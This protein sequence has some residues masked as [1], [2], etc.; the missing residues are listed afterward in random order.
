[1]KETKSHS[2]T[3]SIKVH[4]R[5]RLPYTIHQFPKSNALPKDAV[6]PSH[7]SLSR[8]LEEEPHNKYLQSCHTNHHQAFNYT[9]IKD[10]PLRTPDRTEI[11]I[12][13]SAEILLVPG[14]G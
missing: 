11:S 1:M 5:L 10:P 7:I 14:N 3:S 13:S 6:Y 8:A 4:T 2:L 9:E 12:L